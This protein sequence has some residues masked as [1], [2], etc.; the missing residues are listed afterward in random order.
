MQ[1]M[2]AGLLPVEAPKE[3][4]ALSRPFQFK[5]SKTVC[6]V[7]L[8]PKR[9][10]NQTMSMQGA[11]AGG[12]RLSECWFA[13]QRAEACGRTWTSFG[14]QTLSETS[15]LQNID[16]TTINPRFKQAWAGS[17]FT[18]QRSKIYYRSFACHWHAIIFKIF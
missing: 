2:A 16:S 15:N 10:R 3:A 8:M 5:I 7:H 17:A 14:P 9:W 13:L 18:H 1:E 4:T 11:G 12:K 6:W